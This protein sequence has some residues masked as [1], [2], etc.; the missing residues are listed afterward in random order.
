[1]DIGSSSLLWICADHQLIQKLGDLFIVPR[2]PC[3]PVLFATA[4]TL[5]GSADL[6]LVIGHNLSS[7]NAVFIQTR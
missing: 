4:I 1:L 6:L 2:A 7:K 5:V 3:P